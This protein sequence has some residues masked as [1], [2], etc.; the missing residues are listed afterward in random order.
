MEKRL[1]MRY[2]SGLEYCDGKCSTCGRALAFFDDIQIY[3]VGC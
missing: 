2:P 1:V 3:R